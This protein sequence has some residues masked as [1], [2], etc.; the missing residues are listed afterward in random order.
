MK[1]LYKPALF[2]QGLTN[3]KIFFFVAVFF[4]NILFISILSANTFLW[5]DRFAACITHCHCK[6]SNLR[7]QL[8]DNKLSTTTTINAFFIFHPR[9]Q[10]R[11]PLIEPPS[12]CLR[13]CNFRN[14]PRNGWTL[15]TSHKRSQHHHHRRTQPCSCRK[16]S[17]LLFPPPSSQGTREFIQNATHHSCPTST[18]HLNRFSVAHTKINYLVLSPGIMTLNGRDETS[19]G[20]W[21]KK[22]AVHYY[23]R[24]RFIHD[25]LPSLERAKEAGEEAK[26]MSVLGSGKGGEIDVEDLGLKKNFSLTN[27]ALAAR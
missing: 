17:S 11:L 23:A 19:E 14:W 18:P 25:L 3:I 26:T 21:P 16:P 5:C 6:P 24:S 7:H 22:L 1:V 10:C 13:G 15:C 8:W 12:C 2:F 4:L 20:N 27:A 9:F